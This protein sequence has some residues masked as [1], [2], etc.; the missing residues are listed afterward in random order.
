MRYSS[1][2]YSKATLHAGLY[3]KSNGRM[4][5]ACS[6]IAIHDNITSLA[7]KVKFLKVLHL[8][9][10]GFPDSCV[11]SIF[12]ALKE[13]SKELSVVPLSSNGIGYNIIQAVLDSWEFEFPQCSQGQ[14]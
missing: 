13:D 11:L 1:E 7:D 6:R 8:R 4:C 3:S 10:V 2:V 14:K 5:L 9:K 12:N